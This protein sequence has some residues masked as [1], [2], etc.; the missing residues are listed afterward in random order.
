MKTDKKKPVN[1]IK[2]GFERKKK[3]PGGGCGGKR[4]NTKTRGKKALRG[5]Q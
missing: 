2:K 4:D 3:N 1:P 5:D